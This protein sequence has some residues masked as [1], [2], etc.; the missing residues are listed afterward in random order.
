M[1]LSSKNLQNIPILQY[2][3]MFILARS[4]YRT[5]RNYMGGTII[6]MGMT[7]YEAL[8]YSLEKNHH[9]FINLKNVRRN[10]LKTHRGLTKQGKRS[11]SF[12]EFY[13]DYARLSIAR[14]I[15]H[16]Y[17]KDFMN[18][19]EILHHLN[20]LNILR[21]IRNDIIHKAEF[22]SD[23]QIDYTVGKGF[24]DIYN[25]T[26]VDRKVKKSYKI[27]IGQLWESFLKIYD[28]LNKELLKIVYSTID[29]DITSSLVKEDLAI[30][31]EAGRH[32]IS[33]VPNINWR[34]TKSFNF[35]LEPPSVP[36]ELFPINLKTNDDKEVCINFS[37]DTK[38]FE[39]FSP[40]KVPINLS[41][42]EIKKAI[43][44]K[45][46][47]CYFLRNNPR[48]YSSC[49]T[50]GYILPIHQHHSYHNNK[51]PSCRTEFDIIKKWLIAGLNCRNI[52]KYNESI[53]FSNEVLKINPKHHDALNNIG[54]CYFELKNYEESLNYLEKIELDSLGDTDR[55][56]VFLCHKAIT[57]YELN[58]KEM[59]E[60][61]LKTASLLNPNH[62]FLLFNQCIYLTNE[63]KIDD[64]T[65]LCERLLK[66]D[67]FKPELLY[68]KSRIVAQKH[69]DSQAIKLLSKAI[70]LKPTLRKS[71]IEQADFELIRDLDDFKKILE[72]IF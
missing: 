45:N 44:Q 30:N 37:K 1:N 13:T 68:L 35:T 12:L 58:N 16:Y 27:D 18:F 52:E 21:W 66:Q 70:K 53:A 19:K 20:N 31:T 32:I 61:L 15:K 56:I 9:H 11:F 22:K 46:F 6:T 64:A 41:Y 28:V 40:I 7:V 62:K 25:I 33:I 26:Y 38:D 36:P 23:V 60:D 17:K 47:F 2:Q 8:L 49:E 55:K 72:L 59:C 48:I 3:R 5:N 63:K 4:L 39:K 14:F 10:L 29:W 54:V 51:C 67:D 24:K 34:E 65:I 43:K 69:L 42:K 57:H 50:C 71:A